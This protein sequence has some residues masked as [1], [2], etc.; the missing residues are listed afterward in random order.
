MLRQRRLP[1][2]IDS[3]G[4]VVTG[5]RRHGNSHAEHKAL[6]EAIASRRMDEAEAGMRTHLESV[7]DN[8]LESYNGQGRRGAP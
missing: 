8:L 4:L 6:V 7:R 5:P 2:S 3:V 1:D